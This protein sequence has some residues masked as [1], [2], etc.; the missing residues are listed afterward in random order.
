MN[1]VFPHSMAA[2]QESIH[3]PVDAD[4]KFYPA[5]TAGGPESGMNGLYLASTTMGGDG[6][7]Y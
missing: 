3:A 4:R 6:K 1:H 5:T 7:R 2:G